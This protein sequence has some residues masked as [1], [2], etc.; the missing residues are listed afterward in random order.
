MVIHRS[1]TSEVVH[2]IELP[3]PD[4]IWSRLSL[5]AQ[6][7]FRRRFTMPRPERP[8]PWC[9]L[10]GGT[11]WKRDEMG[12]DCEA[13]LSRCLP[14]IGWWYWRQQ[15]NIICSLFA[16]LCEILRWRLQNLDTYTCHV[17]TWHEGLQAS[18]R[19]TTQLKFYLGILLPSR[20]LKFSFTDMESATNSSLC[21]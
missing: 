6:A 9:G 13:Q 4:N 20:C 2:L 5:P 16:K 21:S 8:E 3:K 18:E 17:F 15:C 12:G 19:D 10:A 1:F 11:G 14:N 7:H